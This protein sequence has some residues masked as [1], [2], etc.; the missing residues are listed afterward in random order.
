MK[1]GPIVKDY[2]KADSPHYQRANILNGLKRLG[3]RV[4]CPV[5]PP[6]EP[7]DVLILWNRY[8]RFEPE[9]RLYEHVGAKVIIVENGFIGKDKDGRQL[10]AMALSQ[11]SGAGQWYVG[12][13][14]RWGRLGIDTQPW[15]L[16]GREIVI[17]PQRGMGKQGTA[18]P[19]D[20][21]MTVVER[22]KKVTDRPIR[23]RP[24]P[25]QNREDPCYD[26]Q[27]AWAAVTWAS[28][29]GIKAIVGGISVFCDFPKWIGAPASTVG[30]DDIENRFLGDRYPMLNRLA[31]AQWT[32]EEIKT[33]EPFEWLLR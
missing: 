31:Y 5:F 8:E 1:R 26:M 16:Q 14:D 25:G 10:Y 4:D 2:L 21:P 13:D 12:Q 32:I 28:G 15:R 20:W 19:R 24:H 29:A 27:D 6:P 22:L 18:M 17:L 23:I 9:A 11:H 3:Y 33:G 30:I 7:G